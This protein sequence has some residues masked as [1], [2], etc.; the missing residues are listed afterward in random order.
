MVKRIVYYPNR[1]P[2]AVTVIPESLKQAHINVLS[3]EKL[4]EIGEK[5]GKLHKH[6]KKLYY[7]LS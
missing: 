1:D 7:L 5:S 6:E 4:L 2:T 3:F